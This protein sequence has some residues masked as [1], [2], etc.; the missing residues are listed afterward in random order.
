MALVSLGDVGGGGAGTPGSTSKK[1]LWW[2]LGTLPLLTNFSIVKLIKIFKQ[3]TEIS[4]F[5][6]KGFRFTERN[7]H[8]YKSAPLRRTPALVA[9]LPRGIPNKD[10]FDSSRIQFADRW[11][12][13]TNKTSAAKHFGR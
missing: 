3:D 8:A 2:L 5:A 9:S 13:I 6:I 7:M 10:T 4:F 11:P 1:I 12:V